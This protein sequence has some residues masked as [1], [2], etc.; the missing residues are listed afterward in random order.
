MNSG[1]PTFELIRDAI[2]QTIFKEIEKIYEKTLE[3]FKAKLE[4]EKSHLLAGVSLHIM[5]MVD[6]ENA[7][8]RI[9][10]TLRQE[11]K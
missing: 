11:T 4:L 6:I 1:E 2:N 3:D 9:V 7:G 10:L 8:N 5:K